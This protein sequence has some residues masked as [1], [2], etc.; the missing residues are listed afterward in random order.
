MY[1]EAP[2]LYFGI[3]TRVTPRVASALAQY[4]VKEVKAHPDVPSFQPEMVR[5]ME[6]LSH[7]D[8]WMVRLGGFHLKKNLLE[9]VQRGR[10]SR[11]HQE[12]FIPSLARGVEFGRPPV[13]PGEPEGARY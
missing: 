8:D 7:A 9:S 13:R 11:E 3:G 1:L 2:Y 6:T 5:A 4:G 12:S 10:G